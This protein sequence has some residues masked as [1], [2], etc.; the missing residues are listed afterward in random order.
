[1]KR[2]RLVR[3]FLEDWGR[4]HPGG[5]AAIVVCC[6]CSTFIDDTGRL[7]DRVVLLA[8]LFVACV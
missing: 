8:A 7:D 2:R 3:P 1:L 6:G 4:W 5:F